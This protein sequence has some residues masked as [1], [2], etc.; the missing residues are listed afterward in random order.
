M[1][2][3]L[4][5]QRKIFVKEFTN[6]LLTEKICERTMEL[7]SENCGLDKYYHKLLFQGGIIDLLSFL[8]EFH[9]EL[10]L[11]KLSQITDQPGVTH[12][13]AIATKIRVKLIDKIILQKICSFYGN[14]LYVKNAI[15]LGFKTC[16]SIWKYA[17]DQSIDYNY[18][19]KRILLLSVYFPSLMYYLGDD[20]ENFEKTDRFI[21]SSLKNIV[22]I[23]RLKNKINLPKIEN[24]PI[25]RMFF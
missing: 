20:S 18:Y 14:P 7:A 3:L 15:K 13:I 8:S 24:I 5:N 2:N 11:S 21:E 25:L 1:E 16:S 23:A 4:Q 9:D 6:L 10:I 19:S 22:K 17:G 12:K